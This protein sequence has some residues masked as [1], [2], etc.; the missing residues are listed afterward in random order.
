MA[1]KMSKREQMK[2]D[3]V[4]RNQEAEKTND[5]F[6]GT[7]NNSVMVDN[8]KMW[9]C[10]EDEHIVDIIPYQVGA[11]HPN[12]NIKEGEWSYYFEF[13][14]HYNVGPMQDQF[15]CLKETFNKKCPIC[16]QKMALMRQENYDEDEVKSLRAKKRTLY[17]I[18]CYDTP[19]EEAKGNQVWHV[20]HWYM[21]KNI[22]PL[23]KN[24]RTGACIAF[25][26][27]D[28]G[29]SIQFSRQGT[30][31]TGKYLGHV[32]LDREDA[33]G[34]KYIISDELLESA[35]RLEE[36][37]KEPTY[38]E[39]A[40]AFYGQEEVPNDDA[41]EEAVTKTPGRRTPTK[42]VAVEEQEEVSEAIIC[43]AGG[44]YGDDLSTLPECDDC[45]SWD[46]CRASNAESK[47]EEK[48]SDE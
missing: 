35:V 20:A 32:F 37:I 42:P 27:P 15:I 33:D 46:D 14:A 29:K 19:D 26:D 30:G 4:K 41:A 21:Q 43:P 36:C 16:E 11:N 39:V 1:K 5:N 13:F 48:A 28:E 44:T 17:N 38:D 9:K 31:Q 3:L 24:K 2:Q 6:G 47:A 10:G 45:E 8:L 22:V 40:K 18:V 23:A 7:F 12:P 34:N 25:A